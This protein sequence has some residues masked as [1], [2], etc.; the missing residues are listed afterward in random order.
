M[1]RQ[2]LE[3]KISDILDGVIILESMV[4]QAMLG[5]VKALVEKDIEA[6]K[7]IY[8][9]DTAINEKRYQLES[10]TISVI[11]RHQPVAVDV[12]ILTSVLEVITEL[13]RMGDYA[14]GIA[15][16][17]IMIGSEPFIKPLIDIPRM[18]ELTAELLRRSIKAFVDQDE[19][20]ARA[21]PLEDDRVDEYYYA[22][23]TELIEVMTGDARTV[24]QANNLLW[25]AH[26][27][28][29]TADRVT[30]ICERT[31]F[32]ITGDLADL[33][34]SDDELRQELDQ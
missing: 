17:N 26:N 20:A 10:E 1:S 11:A 24:D 33:D 34:D 12:R 18:A 5:A 6:S 27:I 9:A 4:E 16:I 25:V 2:I 29:R 31:L 22:V 21:I 30:N 32:I 19:K 23:Y 7:R 3:Q 28:E 14:K 8:E 15:N 13:E